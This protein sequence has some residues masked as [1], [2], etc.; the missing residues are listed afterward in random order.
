MLEKYNKEIDALYPKALSLLPQYK[1]T[2]ILITDLQ[3]KLLKG[4]TICAMIM[5]RMEKEGLVSGYN[6]ATPR[7]VYS[8]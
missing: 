4:Y 5:E 1:E 8:E 7:K 6:G 3:R 2:G